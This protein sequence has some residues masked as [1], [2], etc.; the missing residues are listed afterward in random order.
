MERSRTDFPVKAQILIIWKLGQESGERGRGRVHI[1]LQNHSL[2]KG[3]RRVNS[4]TNFEVHVTW[5]RPWNS[6]STAE[7][8][9]R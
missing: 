6:P 3:G 5:L 1:E 9:A 8:G 7:D 4:R 2:G